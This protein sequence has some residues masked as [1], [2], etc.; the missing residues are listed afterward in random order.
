MWIKSETI[1]ETQPDAID[2]TSSPTTIYER[3]NFEQS[4]RI[5]DD[6]TESTVWTYEE[7]KYSNRE[8]I[9]KMNA[10]QQSLSDAVADMIMGGM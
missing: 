10:E 4:Q 2:I 7:M 5:N 6:G 9:D 3:R 1:S 8:Y